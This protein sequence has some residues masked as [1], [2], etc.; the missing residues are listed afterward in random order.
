MHIFFPTTEIIVFLIIQLIILT[1]FLSLP[2]SS[3]GCHLIMLM[4]LSVG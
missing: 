4:V 3:K 2:P 1:L